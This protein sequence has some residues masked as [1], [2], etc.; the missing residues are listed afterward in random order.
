MSR[1][2]SYNSTFHQ[3]GSRALIYAAWERGDYSSGRVGR[4]AAP[5][6]AFR[7]HS[8]EKDYVH[9]VLLSKQP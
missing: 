3:P 1:P 4:E 2:Q 7:D 5:A 9:V 8:P 6:L